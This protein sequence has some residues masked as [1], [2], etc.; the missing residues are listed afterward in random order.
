MSIVF[1]PNCQKAV[2]L[3][4]QSTPEGKTLDI[5][6]L[7]AACYLQD[8]IK[9]KYPELEQYLPKPKPVRE[10]V[11]TVPVS[12]ELKP[13]LGVYSETGKPVSVDLLFYTL[14]SSKP[15]Q[16]FLRKQG[17]DDDFLNKTAEK[18][19]RDMKMSPQ[20]PLKDNWRTSP[21][22]DR[23][24][25]SLS[26]FGRMLTD[27]E[28]PDRGRFETEGAFRALITTM[29][30]MRRH[31]A[32]IV[33]HP[34]TGKTALVYEFA[35]RMKLNDSLLPAHLKEMDIFELSP[36][37][38]RSGAS[39]VG[40]Y[41]ERVKQLLSVLHDNPKIILF[42]DE[43]HSLFQSGVYLHGPFSDA[44]EAFKGALGRGDISCIGCTTYSEYRH[45]IEP[46]GAL[47]RRFE[48]IRLAPPS[49]EQTIS[50]LKSRLPKFANHYSE[51]EIPES[52]IKRTVELTEDYLPSRY[53]PDKSI[54]LLDH[55]CAL[56]VTGQPKS[57]QLHE[58]HLLK[59][60]EHTVGH[61]I[62]RAEKLTEESVY[63]QLSEK[64]IGHDSLLRELS[65]VFVAGLGSWKQSKGPRGVYLFG[66]PTGTGKTETAKVLG[67]ILG[68]DREAMIRIDCNTLQGVGSE[69]TSV[70]WRLLGVPQGY[71]GY[72]RGQGGLLSRIR[73]IPECIVLF[74]EFEKANAAVGE[75]LLQIM[76]EGKAEDVDGNLL[77]FRRS[78][79]I[80]TSNAGCSYEKP[81]NFGFSTVQ[82]GIQIS[83]TEE[84]LRQDLLRRGLGEEFLARIQHTF[85]FN[86]LDKP[87]LE[88]IIHKQ[89][90]ELKE[91]T[92]KRGL[93]LIWQEPLVGHLLSRWQPQL[94]VRFLSLILRNRV[95]EQLALADAQGELHG[96]KKIILE[97]SETNE[98]QS[99]PEP[100]YIARR[101]RQN[102]T[103]TI[104]LL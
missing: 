12:E 4:K 68:S 101:F 48:I 86:C 69:A 66:G 95:N 44:N 91:K 58:A 92:E 45:F 62:I 30:K 18:L 75:V 61:K 19:K 104:K 53:Q 70:A 74:D 49:I 15:G 89:L 46:D 22:R 6:S 63:K 43:I 82:T 29:S 102:D 97:A 98:Q 7:M 37:F 47:I 76:D 88:K 84:S 83:I 40:Q 31:N 27:L 25:K 8:S 73:D 2:D 10:K 87:A 55:A 23:A 56:A 39:V 1:E 13:I 60:L 65:C 72:A 54:Q 67:Q 57:K 100:S 26:S 42:V 52:I 93:V 5:A 50:I 38:L 33:G 35:R 94:G 14:F 79:L 17:A 24:L 85:L 34:G 59:G 80:F 41:E 103:L 21:Q 77:D 28:L 96:V 11:D 81:K 3:A 90:L 16:G 20:E 64:I 32:I 9:N 78:Y 99:S 51:L 71:V 36:A